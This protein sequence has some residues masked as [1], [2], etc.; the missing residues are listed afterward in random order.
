MDKALPKTDTFKFRINPEVKEQ[1][2]DIF[3]KNGLTLTQAIN[4]FIQQSI[5]VGGLPFIVSED[6]SEI[7]KEYAY[8]RLIK[9]L[10]YGEESGEGI[11]FI[12][13]KKI[14]GIE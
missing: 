1:V 3:E 11:P 6:N 4:I 12:E 5:N 13:A 7:L 2:E 9:E 10:E 14:M 8:K